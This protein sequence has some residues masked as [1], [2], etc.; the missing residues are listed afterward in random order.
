MDRKIA[1]VTGAS[2]GIGLRTAETLLREGFEVFGLCRSAG[3]DEQIQ[4][5][6]CDVTDSQNVKDAFA[7]VLAQAGKIDLLVCN[8]GIGI[9]GAAEFTAEADFRR[10]M[11]VNLI[12]AV[13]CAQ[14]AVPVM[15]EQG[16]GKIIF[17]SS[18]AAIFPLPFQSFYSASKAALNSFSDALGIELKPFNVETCVVMLNDVKTEFTDNRKK[19]EDGDAVYGGRIHKSVA[20]MEK[21]EQNGMPAERVAETICGLL[22]RRHL[23]SHKIVGFSNEL[24]GI[25]YRILPANLMLWLLEKI[26]G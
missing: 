17:V 25:L 19:T 3:P 7:K 15:R 4:W 10:Q 24:L 18:L 23:P 6:P 21:S 26:Y 1:V 14:Q 11:D 22:R 12:G 2:K 8:A 13:C 20:K 16:R 5:I 9:S